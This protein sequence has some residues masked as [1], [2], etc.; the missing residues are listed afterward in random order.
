MMTKARQREREKRLQRASI[1]KRISAAQGDRAT[2]EAMIKIVDALFRSL[3][4]KAAAETDVSIEDAIDGS[5]SLFECGFFRLVARDDGHVGVE[6]CR[7]NRAE[8][9]MQATE[10][11]PLVELRRQMLAERA[12]PSAGP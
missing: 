9:S 11:R 7:E 6:P 1:A 8:Q 5:W 10:N 2:D 4:E 3:A 12:G